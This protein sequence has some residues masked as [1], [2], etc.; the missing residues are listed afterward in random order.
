MDKAQLRSHLR[1]QLLALSDRQRNEKSRNVCKNLINS[2]PFQRAS[3]IMFYLSMPNEVDTTSAILYCWQHEK[4]VAVPKVSWQQ[5]HMIPVEITSL[6][7]GLA[8][9]TSGMRNPVT[10]LPMPIEEID[11]VIT[12]GLAFDENGNRLGKGG[13]YYDRFFDSEKFRADKVA[14]AFSEQIVEEI[15]ITESDRKV[16]FLI[17]DKKIIKCPN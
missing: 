6:E 10:G 13:G 1:K 17:T 15:P 2:E 7:V 12:P 8:I 5:R 11:L 16:D 14:I 9:E 4:T 3:V